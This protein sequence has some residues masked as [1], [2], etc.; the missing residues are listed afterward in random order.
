MR[1]NTSREFNLWMAFFRWEM[2]EHTPLHHYLA[3]IALAIFQS[4]S[5]KPGK[6]KL[7]QFL[8]KF[9]FN[10]NQERS[11]PVDSKTAWLTGLGFNADG[12]PSKRFVTRKPPG[13]RVPRKLQPV[14]P[15]VPRLPSRKPPL[16][17]VPVNKDDQS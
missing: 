7:S 1:T 6:F 12:T 15:R 3:Q 8:L 4:N 13:L 11:T 9:Q 2:N 17:L 16:D 14:A 10:R 5:R